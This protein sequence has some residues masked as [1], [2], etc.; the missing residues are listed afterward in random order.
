MKKEDL[1]DI[2]KKAREKGI[3]LTKAAR[4]ELIRVAA[5]R[6]R[7]TSRG[8][9]IDPVAERKAPQK[10]AKKA[11]K[12]TVKKAVK[13]AVKVKRR[14]TK[15][16]LSSLVDSV[17]ETLEEGGLDSDAAERMREVLE[18]SIR[19]NPD[20]VKG[21]RPD[22][23]AEA[24]SASATSYRV[25]R[26]SAFVDGIEEQSPSDQPIRANMGKP[27]PFDVTAGAI[28]KGALLFLRQLFG[29]VGIYR[30]VANRDGTVDV[31]VQ[32]DGSPRQ[33]MSGRKHDALQRIRE[34]LSDCYVS[35][36]TNYRLERE[37]PS[38]LTP[39]EASKYELITVGTTVSRANAY[40]RP[41]EIAANL[42]WA[43]NTEEGMR[44]KG[45][46]PLYT[47]VRLHWTGD[48]G[49]PKRKVSG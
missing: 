9:Y 15:E 12:K 20:A 37:L 29:K 33:F 46:E 49:P 11:A 7:V 4:A 48:G 43:L 24:L 3:V 32:L 35:F 47:T 27:A 39:D 40:Q 21:L 41:E 1:R 14:A 8:V 42:N 23:I 19:Q 16:Q 45:F 13:K 18:D 26:D 25:M 44:E 30:A 2:A 17:V 28:A 38:S 22:D 6:V 34:E 31:A 36:D 5:S 10:A